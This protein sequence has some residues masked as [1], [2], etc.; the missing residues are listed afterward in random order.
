MLILSRVYSSPKSKKVIQMSKKIARPVPLGKGHQ[1]KVLNAT[2]L[3][4]KNVDKIK[5]PDHPIETESRPSSMIDVKCFSCK[6]DFRINISS[7][8][9]SVEHEKKIYTCNDCLSSMIGG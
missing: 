6:E 8:V 1:L 2:K 5:M 3:D 4:D 9:F 7:L